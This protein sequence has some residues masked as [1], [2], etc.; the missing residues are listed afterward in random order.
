MKPGCAWLRAKLPQRE[1]NRKAE[2]KSLTE[3]MKLIE[4]GCCLEA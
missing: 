4:V 2:A 1:A 3:A